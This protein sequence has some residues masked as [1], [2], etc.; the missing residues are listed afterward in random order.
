MEKKIR[1]VKRLHG[2]LLAL[3]QSN[4]FLSIEIIELIDEE[5]VKLLKL[6]AKVLDGSFLFINELNRID[7]Q[8]YSY[9]WQ[10][11]NGELIIRWDNLPHCKNIKTFPHHKHE[12]DIVLPSHRVNIDD[13]IEIIKERIFLYKGY[14]K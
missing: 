12:N 10:K 7:Y 8:K 3:N 2:I 11:E 5:S 9:H 4:L 1:G 6:K 14:L 13:V